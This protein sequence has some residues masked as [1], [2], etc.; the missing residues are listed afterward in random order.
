MAP[1]Q[2]AWR[3]YGSFAKTI[4]L[5]CDV[6]G[7]IDD[8][9]S[10]AHLILQGKPVLGAGEDLVKLVRTHAIKRVLVAIPSATEDEMVRI[11]RFA[12]EA[13]VEYKLVPGLGDIIQ[14]AELGAQI[15]SG[16]VTIEHMLGRR[17]EDNIAN[18]GQRVLLIG[19]AGYIGSGL[20]P[21]L[22]NYGYRVRL[23]DAFL[24]GDDPISQWKNHP[25]LEIVEADF[26]RVDIVVRAMRDV[27]AVVHL[28]AIVGDPA[29]A[30]DEE[31]TIET[32]LLATRMIAEVTKGEGIEKFIFASS[33]SVYGASDSYLDEQ[34]PLHPVSL[35]AR[36]KL[37]CENVLMGMKNEAFRPI[38]LRFGTIYGLSGRTRFDLV[39]NLLTAKA[40]VDGAIAVFGSDQWRPFLHV[41]D[42]AR[43][44][45][46]ALQ[47]ADETVSDTIF[48]VGSDDQNYTLGDVGRL[49]K[50][51]VPSSNL[52]IYDN[53]DVDRRNYRVNFSRIQKCMGYTPKW[54]LTDGIEQVIE[55][56]RNGKIKDYKNP[57]YSNVRFLS[58]EIGPESLR[59]AAQCWAHD[60]LNACSDMVNAT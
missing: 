5:M 40:M 57:I 30:L 56:I 2:R 46:C 18:D 35:Y 41:D 1:A 21:K 38:I 43:A 25:G 28:G 13:E 36:S 37:A 12:V 4:L 10:K 11:L 3:C 16:S 24:Y 9:P 14:S 19:G 55:A 42:A 26:R 54:K 23:L 8:D 27:K 58:E 31:L 33:C 6:V 45:Y 32:N 15:R 51:M 49:I 50:S 60:A 20:L 17:K 52:E 22:L 39:V 59:F 48:N 44:V 7:L 47:A 29:C 34:S 53:G